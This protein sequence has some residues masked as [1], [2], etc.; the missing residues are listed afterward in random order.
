MNFDQ[1]LGDSLWKRRGRHLGGGPDVR[2]YGVS[3]HEIEFAILQILTQFL[4]WFEDI[5]CLKAYSDQNVLLFAA[6][7]DLSLRGAGNKDQ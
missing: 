5:K 6:A 1:E 4:G 7:A 2:G 3:V